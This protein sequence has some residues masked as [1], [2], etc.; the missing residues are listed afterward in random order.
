MKSEK[1]ED[2]LPFIKQ[3]VSRYPSFTRLYFACMQESR[4]L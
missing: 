3:G 2:N 1:D 4:L